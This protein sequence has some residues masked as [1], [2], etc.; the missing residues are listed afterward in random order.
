MARKSTLT[1]IGLSRRGKEDLATFFSELANLTELFDRRFKAEN[2]S[3]DPGCPTIE[4]Q[5]EMTQRS[6]VKA[7]EMRSVI[8]PVFELG[9][10]L[11]PAQTDAKWAR[12]ISAARR[13]QFDRIGRRLLRLLDGET[14]NVRAIWTF[15]VNGGDVVR[16]LP[17]DPDDR[18]FALFQTFLLEAGF[19]FTR[20]GECGRVLAA[21]RTDQRFCGRKCMINHRRSIPEEKEKRREYMR[22]Y[23]RD[24]RVRKKKAERKREQAR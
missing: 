23:M 11:F 5:Y 6:F 10:S 7:S 4:E 12:P 22:N 8:E 18:F 14:V 20:C 1:D 19:P 13:I 17:D 15:T 9:K 24:R 3:Y 2:P 21:T 16:G